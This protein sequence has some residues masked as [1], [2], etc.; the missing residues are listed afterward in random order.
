MKAMTAATWIVLIAD[1][2]G[3]RYRA[4]RM[5]E[6]PNLEY[7]HVHEIGDGEA[8]ERR[9]REPAAPDSASETVVKSDRRRRGRRRE[10]GCGSGP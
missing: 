9:Y 3:A 10:E 4:R 2:P 6:A 5:K 1:L 7:R 8:R